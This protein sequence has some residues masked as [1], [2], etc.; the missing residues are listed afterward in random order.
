MPTVS[1]ANVHGRCRPQLAETLPPHSRPPCD[2]CGD[3]PFIVVEGH[4]LCRPWPLP[5][6]R[7][8]RYARRQRRLGR[9]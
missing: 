7:D 8:R 6:M 5:A 4:G 1:A 9:L 3:P 2:G